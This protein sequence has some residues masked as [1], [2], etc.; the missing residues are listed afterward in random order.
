MSKHGD[1]SSVSMRHPSPGLA[2]GSG[3]NVARLR[4]HLPICLVVGL[5]LMLLPIGDH[6]SVGE[7]KY[8]SFSQRLRT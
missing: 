2:A 4:L 7:P 6:K 1:D 3:L 8:T 5:V